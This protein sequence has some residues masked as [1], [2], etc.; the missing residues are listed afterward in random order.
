[1]GRRSDHSRPELEALLLREGARLMAEVGFAHFSAR[2]VAKRAGYS[3]GTVANIFGSVD[4]LVT[5]INSETFSMWAQWLEDRLARKDGGIRIDALV[6]GYFDFARDNLNLWA[7][8]YEHRLPEGMTMPEPLASRR[9]AL[10]DI[11]VREVRAV[12]PPHTQP[13]GE[14]L[15]RSLIATVH[16][17]CVFALMG[18]FALL[19]ETDPLELAIVRVR[20]CLRAHGSE[21]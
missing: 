7:A 1:M 19:G 10:T 18:T 3:I 14:R 16:G 20:E 13:E 11:I 8:L 15:A 5:A 4:G 21:V 17:H 2:E 9:R 12:L 6:T